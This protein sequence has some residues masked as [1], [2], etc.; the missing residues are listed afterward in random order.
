MWACGVA[1]KA[2]LN[3]STI[4]ALGAVSQEGFGGLCGAAVRPH[5]CSQ[6]SG[7]RFS[8]SGPAESGRGVRGEVGVLQ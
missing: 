2:S 4:L 1:G 6:N 3:L 8:A 7:F 5:S